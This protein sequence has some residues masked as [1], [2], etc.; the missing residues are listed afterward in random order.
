MELV[1]AAA[2]MLIVVIGV[3]TVLSFAAQS[4]QSNAIRVRALNL[5]NQRLEQSRNLPYDSLGVRYDGG[6][7]GNPAG[8]ILTP[9]VIDNRFTVTT[10]VGWARDP[11]THRALY[12]TIHVTV[13]WTEGRGGLVDVSTSVFG[14]SALVNTGDLSILVRDRVT[15]EPLTNAQV[16]ITPTSGTARTVTTGA[17]GEA[18]FGYLPTGTYS[19]NIVKMDYVFDT[20]A[21]SAVAVQADLLTS[22]V[23]YG[24]EPSRV[25]VT[26][27]TAPGVYL[28][29][30]TVTLTSAA[31]TVLTAYSG[32]DGVATF[33]NLIVGAY[34]VA[35]RYTG[36]SSARGQVDVL[37]PGQDYSLSLSL[38]VRNGLTIRVID[39]AL[40]GVSGATVR[41]LGPQP[42]TNNATGSPGVTASNGEVSFGTLDDGT[43]T[44]IA[45][46]SGM[47]D[48]APLVYVYDGSSTTV[49]TLTLTRNEFGNLEINI[50]DDHG[51]RVTSRTRVNATYPN[52][53]VISYR[54]SSSS[55]SVILVSGIPTGQYSVIP[56]AGGQARTVNVQPNQTSVVNVNLP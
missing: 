53:D 5:A 6:G 27:E 54:S 17:D 31:G 18:F 21:L 9:E 19:V 52:G 28:Q 14:K 16:T 1:W 20:A 8:A 47:N 30:A 44:I 32:F 50:F 43:Y 39:S 56:E 26:V 15:D 34:Q 40:A 13:S 7:L 37:S 12:K 3:M 36:R 25:L 2:I 51:N 55:R 48:S 42:G 22:I 4:A 29:G 46:K 10:Q 24:Q 49:Q 45:T 41:V 23:A 38:A 33:D 35:A 11:D